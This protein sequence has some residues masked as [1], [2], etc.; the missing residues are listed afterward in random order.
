MVVRELDDDDDDDDLPLGKIKIVKSSTFFG[1]I[2][3]TNGFITQT[4]RSR[5]YNDL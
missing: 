3:T 4:V 5:D 2:M 1:K